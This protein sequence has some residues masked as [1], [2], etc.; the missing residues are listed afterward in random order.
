MREKDWRECLFSFPRPLPHIF[1]VWPRFS[2]RAAVSL[3]LRNTN[4]HNK[5]KKQNKTKQPPP[6]Q[7]SFIEVLILGQNRLIFGNYD[8][9]YKRLLLSVATVNASPLAFIFIRSFTV[10]TRSDVVLHNSWKSNLGFFIWLL[11]NLLWRVPEVKRTH[12]F[13][14]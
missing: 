13:D 11:R 10:G 8:T 12:V 7:A 3:T 5:N 14:W 6:W 2:F 4:E 9:V 1:L